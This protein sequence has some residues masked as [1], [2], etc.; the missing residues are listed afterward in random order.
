MEGNGD[1]RAQEACDTVLD[2]NCNSLE[3]GMEV[4]GN[5]EDESLIQH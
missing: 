4:N 3:N 5:G 1:G 2:S